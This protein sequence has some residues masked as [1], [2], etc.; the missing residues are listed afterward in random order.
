MKYSVE[1]QPVENNSPIRRVPIAR[2]STYVP[3]IPPTVE[4]FDILSLHAFVSNG[5]SDPDAVFIR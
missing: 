2:T 5:F 4:T 3:F 1:D